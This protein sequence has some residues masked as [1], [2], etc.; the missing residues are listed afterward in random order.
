VGNDIYIEGIAEGFVPVG[1]GDPRGV[2]IWEA[3]KALTFDRGQLANA[4]HLGVLSYRIQ[5]GLGPQSA[6]VCRQRDRLAVQG[7]ASPRRTMSG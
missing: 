7:I 6:T 2:L 3:L 5:S 4:M 1:L